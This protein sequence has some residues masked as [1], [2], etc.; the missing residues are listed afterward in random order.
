MNQSIELTLLAKEVQ[1]II[2]VLGQLP[3]NSGAFPLLMK[4]SVQLQAQTQSEEN[5]EVVEA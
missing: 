4:I 2:N 5:A 1:D 3:T